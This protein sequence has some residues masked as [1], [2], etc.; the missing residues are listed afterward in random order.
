MSNEN[1]YGKLNKKIETLYYEG[2]ESDTAIVT[3]DNNN[4]TIKVDVTDAGD[5][6]ER[7]DK[8]I[9]DRTEADKEL[10]QKISNETTAREV[11]D[12]K[13]NQ[14]IGNINTSIINI[15]SSI[16]NINDNIKGFDESIDNVNKSV[17]ELSTKVDNA[18]ADVNA[19]KKDI[20]NVK[21]DISSINTSIDS[22][23]TNVSNLTSKV[24]TNTIN[25]TNNKNA[26]TNINNK[27]PSD[28]SSTNK[29]VTNNNLTNYVQTTTLTETLLSYL[30]KDELSTELQGY[31]TT[32][33]LNTTLEGYLSEADLNT[34]LNE[35]TT[36]TMFNSHVNNKS[37]PHGVTK[38]Q[39][40]LGN[41]DNTSDIN[42]PLST[43]TTNALALKLDKIDTTST[44]ARVYGIT[45]SGKQSIFELDAGNKDTNPN[46]I[47]LRDSNGNIQTYALPEN[48]NDLINK[49]YVD[50]NIKSNIKGIKD[51][52]PSQASPT[53]QLADKDFV[54]SSINS[55]AAYFIGSFKTYA[56]LMTWQETNPTKATNNDYAYVEEDETHNNEAWRYI[57]VKNSGDTAGTWQAQFKVNNSP[58]TAAQLAAINSNI[59]S[60]K[61]IAY[62]E[63][64]IN[65]NN[66]H[67]VR[68]EQ[69]GLSKVDNTS[70]LEKPIST[71]TQEALD[72]LTEELINKQGTLTSEQ[73]EAVN[74]GITSLKITQYDKSIS[75]INSS[76]STLETKVNTNT[77]NIA[78][79]Q[80][81]LTTAQTNAVNSGVTSTK[82][83]SYDNH[84]NN[85]SNPHNVTK[86]QIGLG[87]VD[88]T[89]DLNKP[90]S[91]KTQEAI[92][93]I[94]TTIP[95]NLK[96]TDNSLQLVHDT[97]NIGESIAVLTPIDSAEQHIVTTLNNTQQ[98][99]TLGNNLEIKDNKLNA[100]GGIEV[101][102]ELPVASETSP[103]MFW[104]NNKAY[105]KV[106][107]EDTSK[108]TLEAGAYKWIDEPSNPTSNINTNINFTCVN[109]SLGFTKIEVE[110]QS[111]DNRKVVIN[112]TNSNGDT[113]YAT[114]NKTGW[115]DYP[116]RQTITLETSQE[117]TQE[118]YTY[119]IANGNL[120]KQ[121]AN[122]NIPLNEGNLTQN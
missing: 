53:N 77:T 116:N 22:L 109:E 58:F 36:L 73:L 90:I 108:P 39:V 49:S 102:T 67:N 117:V 20:S 112:Y 13:I 93:T 50:S 21:N 25:I 69:I 3:V 105:I 74:S 9:A 33:E 81:K 2:L 115:N 100:K 5:L 57:Y 40:G 84:I 65:T 66:P 118:F 7:L 83:T 52:I 114:D 41:V 54:N 35:Y 113:T 92:D 1:I 87:N 99:I 78:N 24:T 12:T 56:D 18:V 91:T 96:L 32:E 103:Y 68:K 16:D 19:V 70:D 121:D 8:E 6:K 110:H 64:I 97:T 62:D 119:A 71:A 72:S 111:V 75:D 107:E 26:I 47:P 4:K 14:S 31:V 60:D 38:E 86:S 23:N 95:N 46:T 85:K 15:N 37:N 120:I 27:I 76:I 11:A 88:N 80:D 34:K 61:V 79:K 48:D 101:L 42:K 59:T 98:N 10:N 51:L 106:I 104:C 55:S 28:A 44:H 82:I 30:T 45:A 89:S 63:H 17:D 29:L 122:P 43:A 94:N